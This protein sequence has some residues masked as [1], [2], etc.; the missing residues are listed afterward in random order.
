MTHKT[1]LQ[2]VVAQQKF[3][4]AATPNAPATKCATNTTSSE[5]NDIVVLSCKTLAGTVV[6]FIRLVNDTE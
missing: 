2:T 3:Q 6:H 4:P 1:V 5:M